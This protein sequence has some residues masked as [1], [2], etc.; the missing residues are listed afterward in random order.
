VLLADEENASAFGMAWLA[1]RALLCGDAAGVRRTCGFRRQ[2]VPAAVA[3]GIPGHSA[4]TVSADARA[5]AALAKGILALV[6]R[7]VPAGIVHP[8]D[9]TKLL[10]NIGTMLSGGMVPFA[11]PSALRAAIEIRTIEGQEQTEVIRAVEAALAVAGLAN[12]VKVEL[13]D[14]PLDWIPGGAIVRDEHLLNCAS[15]AWRTFLVSVQNVV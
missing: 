9:G 2:D 11:H 7:D 8:V 6:E 3:E 12:R 1:D 13:Q 4:E 10:L 14:L 5:S 15:G